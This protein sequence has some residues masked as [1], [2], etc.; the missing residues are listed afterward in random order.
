MT[1]VSWM[2]N[3]TSGL[4]KATI[5]YTFSSIGRSRSS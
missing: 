2:T 5:S 1:D 4:S 3:P